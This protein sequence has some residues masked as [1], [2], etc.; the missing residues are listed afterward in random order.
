MEA[1]YKIRDKKISEMLHVNS[2]I[3]FMQKIKRFTFKSEY[4]VI[5]YNI[6][7]NISR[8]TIFKGKI[9]LTIFQR[10]ENER[11]L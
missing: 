7:D 9:S 1:F 11:S 3:S 4:A 6:L 10:H 2:G 5:E 8:N